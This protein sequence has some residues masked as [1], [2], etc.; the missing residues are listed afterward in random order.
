MLKELTK[1]YKTHMGSQLQILTQGARIQG[2]E[3]HNMNQG[4]VMD[5][6]WTEIGQEGVKTDM[7]SRT[8][9]SNTKKN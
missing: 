7:G 1:V 6:I 5:Q 3:E 8:R 9:I 2:K 4:A